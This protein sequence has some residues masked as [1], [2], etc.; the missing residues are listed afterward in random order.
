MGPW[1]KTAT[2]AAPPWALCVCLGDLGLGFRCRGRLGDGCDEVENSMTTLVP[3]EAK[4]GSV[5]ANSC[6][7]SRWRQSQTVFSVS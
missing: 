5:F 4:S 7:L 1:A 6:C 2:D 3:A